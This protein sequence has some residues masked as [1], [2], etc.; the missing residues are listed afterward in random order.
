MPEYLESNPANESS[1]VSPIKLRGNPDSPIISP[2]S[3]DQ[4]DIERIFV[5][6]RFSKQFDAYLS[7]V[8]IDLLE[9]S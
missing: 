6:A 5:V 8:S 3:V 9:H 4:N 2:F 1:K 7:N